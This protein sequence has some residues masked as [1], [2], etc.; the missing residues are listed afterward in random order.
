MC[1]GGLAFGLSAEEGPAQL[2]VLLSFVLKR[3]RA[4]DVDCCCRGMICSTTKDD[5]REAAP[6][7]VTG[8]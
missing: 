7:F 5:C 6:A 4:C 3:S 1:A 8:P 2:L